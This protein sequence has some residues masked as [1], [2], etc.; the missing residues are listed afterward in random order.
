LKS[1]EERIEILEGKDNKFNERLNEIE[2]QLANLDI[3]DIDTINNSIEKS[4]TE[5]L[6]KLNYDGIFKLPSRMDSMDKRQEKQD[7]DFEDINY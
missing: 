1:H 5:I 6:D 2:R 3:V 4:K 7:K